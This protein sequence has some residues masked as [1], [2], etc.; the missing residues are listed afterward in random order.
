MAVTKIWRIKLS[1]NAALSYISNP[2]KTVNPDLKNALHY[3]ENEEK[4]FVGDEQM[5][6]VTGV[7][8][9]SQSAYEE[10]FKV[11]KR[12][13][14]IGGNVAYHAYQ[15]FKTGE[16]TPQE[17]HKIGIEL[18]QKMWGDEYQVLVATHFNT[19]TYHNHFVVNSVNMWSG[20]KFNCNKGA[21]YRLRGL[22]DEI[23]IEHGLSVIKNP[24]GKTPRNI[25]FA[26]KNGEP[27]K[28]TLMREAIDYAITCSVSHTD[29]RKVMRELGYIVELNPNR[30]YWTIR[31]MNSKKCV[32]MFRLG[33]E[34]TNQRIMER[35]CAEGSKRYS[36]STE[37]WNERSRYR[38]YAPK[39][40]HLKGNIQTARK[41]TGLS[42]FYILFA[43]LLGLYPKQNPKKPLSPE[44]R[45]AWL[46]IERYSNEIR[47][48]YNQKF[49]NLNDVE[50]FLSSTQN[51]ISE[52][53]NT[54]KKI[55][56]KLRRCDDAD[57]KEQLLSQRDLCTE[58][59]I[60]LRNQKKVALHIIE[61]NAEIKEKIKYERQA[62]NH[63][64]G[65]DYAE[66]HRKKG[67]LR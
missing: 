66:K 48:V 7:N 2:K 44:M 24:T 18:A 4:T 23:C 61:D 64:Y 47:L 27:T 42:A 39:K 62:Q 6:Y 30:T 52:L 40:I 17:A 20:K 25:Y 13:N 31:S 11:Q 32:R 14:K 50:Q 26:E 12:F 49:S 3:A 63:L 60:L 35:I 54:R 38:K 10:M 33:D 15:S 55:Y 41:I 5:L 36:K 53:E 22:S 57:K 65:R 58:K 8:C 21:Y 29:F 37:F 1:I 43:Y 45:E 34:Y 16:V 19:G 9:S 51:K 56:N 46:K 28:F 67:Y 59:L